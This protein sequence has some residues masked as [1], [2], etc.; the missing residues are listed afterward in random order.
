MSFSLPPLQQTV[1]D[2]ATVAAL[3]ADLSACAEVTSVTTRAPGRT[4]G[5]APT[6]LS[7]EAA[8]EGLLSGGLRTVQIRYRHGGQTW[9]DT[10]LATPVGVRLVRISEE[11]VL[12]SVAGPTA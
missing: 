2:P 10:L 7:L 9:C 3:F 6:T 8:R 4:A 5:A 1:L 12:A 11:D